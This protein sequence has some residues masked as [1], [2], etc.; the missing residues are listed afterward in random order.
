MKSAAVTLPAGVV[1]DLA[2]TRNVCEPAQFEAGDC[3]AATRIGTATATVAIVPE[4]LT[5]AIYMVR[6]PGRSLPG[7]GLE[8]KGRYPQRVMS[9]V[10][11]D[12]QS[13]L[14]TTF[15]AIPD[16]PLRRWWSM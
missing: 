9:T 13:R 15:P 4:S 10:T 1:A 16:L 6:V 3:P 8:F 11:T 5:G 2:N 14:V 7:L 12:A